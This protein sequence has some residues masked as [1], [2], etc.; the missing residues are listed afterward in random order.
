[1]STSSYKPARITDLPYSD[2]HCHSYCSDGE[3]SPEQLV[4][5]ALEN[6]LK[7]LAITDHD[8]VAG[9]ERAVSAANGTELK[10]ITGT[11]LTCLWGKRVVHIIGL[12]FDFKNEALMDYLDRL[13][14]LR[15]KR[16][17]IIAEKLQKKGCP[18]LLLSATQLA[19]EG[20]VGRPHFAR[21]M[22]EAG[23]VNA[24]NQAFNQYLGA[25][26]VG[27]VKV[28]WPDMAEGIRCIN[29]AGGV[30][31]LAH[32]TKYNLTFTKIRLLLEQFVADGGKGI[33][34]SYPGASVGHI[35]QLDRIAVKHELYISAGSDFHKSSFHWTGLGK[36]P[37]YQNNAPHVL[38][39]L[40]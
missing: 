36:Y 14:I 28:E 34:I 35:N 38:Q 15:K 31:V 9:I 29:S 33:E 12:G 4:Q 16:A 18:D 10:I 21:A 22:V 11:E 40:L 26:K 2:L 27:D 20:Q 25:G 3:L 19:G 24:E 39:T 1:V 23:I 32:P 7:V 8:S 37:R 6:G 13:V 5:N 17:E 30:A